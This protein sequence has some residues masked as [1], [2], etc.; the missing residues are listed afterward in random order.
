GGWVGATL[1]RG[2]ARGLRQRPGQVLAARR[3]AARPRR[4]AYRGQV[5][6]RPPRRQAGARAGLRPVGGLRPRQQRLPLGRRGG[7]AG[8][9][10]GVPRR[11]ARRRARKAAR[12][13][14]GGAARL[15]DGRG[16]RLAPGLAPARPLVGTDLE[17]PMPPEWQQKAEAEYRKYAGPGKGRPAYPERIRFAT[18]TLKTN[19]CDW[20]EL[21]ALGRHYEPARVEA[22]RTANGFTVQTA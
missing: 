20:V 14:A 16:R 5:P 13:A 19:A 4:H 15:L 7:R 17:H 12:P 10:R 22:V 1:R 9:G 3:G 21:L 6:E 18:R 8:G 11:R 2:A